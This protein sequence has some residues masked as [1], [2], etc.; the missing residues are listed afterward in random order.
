MLILPMLPKI[1]RKI[2]RLT[3]L[4]PLLLLGAGCRTRQP[5]NN[6]PAISPPTTP[7]SLTSEPIPPVATDPNFVVEVVNRVGEAV[8]R[9]NA[10]RTVSTRSSDSILGDFFG[11]PRRPSERVEQ[12]TGS[13]FIYN[14][15]GLIMTNRH[16]VADAD[17]VTVVL[18]D[19]RQLEGKVL[20]SDE[21]TDVAVVQIQAEDLPALS[22]G[23]S[24]GIQPGEWAIAIGNPLG[25]DNT[26]TVGIISA[27]GR[28]SSEVG[29]PDQ[30]V[31]FIQTDAAIN[32]GN[33][34]G[35]LLNQNGEVI[36]VNTA[37]ISN[38]QGLGFAIPINLANRIANQ[39][40]NEG[41][42]NRAYIG[43]KMVNLSP[44]VA[45]QIQAQ[46]PEFDISV[47]KGVL[48]VEV[49]RR[50]PAQ[51]SGLEDGDVILTINGNA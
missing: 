1:H 43:V 12:G 31:N 20:G 13:G 51:Q 39:L 35:P 19:G 2:P 30:R 32:P 4:L 6:L 37:I 21:L 7:S 36:G 14:N 8:V 25:L 42:V 33:S 18:K 26:V 47:D 48:V 46:R 9:I 11:V 16:V 50:S 40:E 44:E 41:A 3:L 10:S 15:S 5:E 24:E 22:L 23:N 28:T 34:G 27:T 45:E 49:I 38:A 17:Q 29:I